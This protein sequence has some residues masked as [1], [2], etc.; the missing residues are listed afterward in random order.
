M[1]PGAFWLAAV[2]PLSGSTARAFRA[3]ERRQLVV[4]SAVGLR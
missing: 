1:I 3:V 4:R 2:V